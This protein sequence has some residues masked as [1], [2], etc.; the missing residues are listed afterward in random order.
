MSIKRFRL[1]VIILVLIIVITIS[2]IFIKRSSII[3]KEFKSSEKVIVIDLATEA[4]I[5]ERLV[6]VG[7]MKRI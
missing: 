5:L 2:L 1:V 6:L 3:D 4:V 7:A